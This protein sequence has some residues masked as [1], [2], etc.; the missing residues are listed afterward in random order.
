MA[1]QGILVDYEFCSGCQACMMACQVEHDLPAGREGV[2]VQTVGP[3]A[4]DKD[5]DV[6]Q[7]DYMPAFTDECCL[8]AGRV[9][10]GKL[11]TCVKHCLAAV[12]QYGEVEELAKQLGNKGKQY[13]FVPKAGY[14]A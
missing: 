10:A 3:W 8:C 11:P 2:V 13:L 4:I 5:N 7:F 9:E 6:Y 12:M 1:V 14:S